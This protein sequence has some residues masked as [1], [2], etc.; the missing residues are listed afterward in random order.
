MQSCCFQQLF[1]SPLRPERWESVPQAANGIPGVWGNLLSFLG[2][3]HSCIGYRYS[4]TEYVRYCYLSLTE[5]QHQHRIKALLFA[6]LR[7]FEFQLAVP[8]DSVKGT[9]SIIQRPVLT[10]DPTGKVQLPLL[11]KVYQGP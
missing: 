7:G 2:G 3:R 8:A 1:N 10:S 11:I 9:G 5:S 6:L 4:V